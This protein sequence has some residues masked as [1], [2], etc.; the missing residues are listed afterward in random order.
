MSQS[1]LKMPHCQSFT[2]NLSVPLHWDVCLGKVRITMYTI[3]KTSVLS[4][5]VLVKMK[6]QRVHQ[7]ALWLKKLCLK[8]D[9]CQEQEEEQ[10]L[11]GNKTWMLPLILWTSHL[12]N[13][14]D[15]SPQVVETGWRQQY[16]TLGV[17]PSGWCESVRRNSG[18][19]AEPGAQWVLGGTEDCT[20]LHVRLRS[21]FHKPVPQAGVGPEQHSPGQQL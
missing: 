7:T 1:N 19:T 15:F 4:N 14:P 11:D 5:G 9:K 8:L 21:T 16:G 17:P 10:K 2:C 13:S 20:A 6:L 12:K 18:R 3:N